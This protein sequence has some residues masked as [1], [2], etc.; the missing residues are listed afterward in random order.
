MYYDLNI[1]CSFSLDRVSVDKLKL[2]LSRLSQFNE[3]TAA[4]NYTIQDLK[5][6]KKAN[7]FDTLGINSKYPLSILKR[8]TIDTDTIFNNE[9]IA[10]LRQD[11]DLISLKTRSDELFELACKE[12]N[13]DVISFHFDERL[14]FELNPLLIKRA[15]ER[16][17][18]FEISY[19]PTIKDKQARLYTLQ[20]AKELY[21]CT[22]GQYWIISSE[23]ESVSDIRNPYDIFYL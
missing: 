11:Y 14:S 21:E 7:D 13:L 17:V 5:K 15:M 19:A 20:I 8:L 22:K 18:Y 16:R 4:L 12:L 23:T 6:V 3:C 10:S 2:I 1:P 9:D